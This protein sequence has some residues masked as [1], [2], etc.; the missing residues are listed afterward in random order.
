MITEKPIPTGLKMSIFDCQ[1]VKTTDAKFGILDN[2]IQ[3][4]VAICDTKEE[5][6]EYI[7]I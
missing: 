3:M 6:E 7:K 5:A 2:S 4:L 1:I